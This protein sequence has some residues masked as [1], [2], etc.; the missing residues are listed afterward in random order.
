MMLNTARRISLC[1]VVIVAATLCLPSDVG[2][3]LVDEDFQSPNLAN[4]QTSPAFPGWSWSSVNVKNNDA[5]NNSAQPGAST[6][7]SVYYEYTSY[8][9]EY[10]IAHNWSTNDTYVLSVNMAPHTWSGT[11]QRYVEPSIREQVGGAVLWTSTDPIPT[12]PSG[13][14]YGGQPWPSELTFQYVIDASTFPTATEGNAIRLRVAHSGARGVWADNISLTLGA[15][16]A[17]SNPPTP[18][19]M[20]WASVP[21]V[22]SNTNITMTATTAVDDSPFGVEYYF[23][24]TNTAANSGWQDGT[25]WT[26]YDIAPAT[27]YWYR[28]KARDKSPNTNE[29][30]WSSI[31]SATTP[32]PDTTPPTPDPPTWSVSPTLVDSLNTYMQIGTVTDPW[33]GVEYWIENKTTGANT[34]WQAGRIFSETCLATGASYTYRAKARDTSPQ[35]NETSWSSEVIVA[36]P[37]P[38]AA[39]LM[40]DA[41]FQS[42]SNPDNGNNP[43]FVG[44]SLVNGNSVKVQQSSGDGVPGPAGANRVIHF[45]QTNA[46]IYYDTCAQWSA[47][48]VYGLTINAA[49]QSWSGANQRYLEISLRQTD[50][51]VLWSDTTT[52]PLY[53]AGFAG[54]DP[55]PTNLTFSYE[56]NASDFVTGTEGSTLRL[57]VDS[58]G[59]RG[60]FIDDVSL[61]TLPPPGS[62]FILE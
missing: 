41:T 35:T 52:I 28:A 36:I 39:G 43:F 37:A 59:Q 24:N 23:E 31:L 46:E 53:E 22:V 27:E 4:N 60:L 9:G 1:A 49:P 61:Q 16:P 3:Q 25:S 7:Q 26:Q 34:G 33:G 29:T 47:D 40:I 44:W 14:P 12:I 57:Y 15:P 18:D 8:Y 50:N 2:A 62:V 58:S 17:E 54:A 13:N 32:A 55:W 51:T 21:A 38:A 45:E 48:D 20:T 56:I 19:P 6:N 10:N 30:A 42:P 5:V 11:S